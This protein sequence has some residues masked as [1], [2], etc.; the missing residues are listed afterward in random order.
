MPKVS[1]LESLIKFCNLK[2]SNQIDY[3]ELTN[4]S[5]KIV[6]RIIL[7]KFKV[8]LKNQMPLKSSYKFFAIH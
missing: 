1:N 4:I 7:D 6:I 2:I 8:N 5:D 3:I